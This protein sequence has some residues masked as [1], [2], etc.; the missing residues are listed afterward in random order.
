[1][2]DAIEMLRPNVIEFEARG[3]NFIIDTSAGYNRRPSDERAFTI[4]KTTEYLNLYISLAK[5]I[6]PNTVLELGV[7]Q[8][9]SY[10]FLD[11]VFEPGCMSAVELS[12]KPVGPLLAWT[13]HKPGRSVHFGHNQTDEDLLNKSLLTSLAEP[14]DLCRR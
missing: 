7:F 4:V 11:S 13:A 10:V 3:A 5:T 9:G 14:L 2:T 12:P 8:G 1:M 6:R